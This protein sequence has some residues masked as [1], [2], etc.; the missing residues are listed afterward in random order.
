MTLR[1]SLHY[2][3][4]LEANTLHDLL[5][6]LKLVEVEFP[7]FLEGGVCGL[8]K[9]DGAGVSSGTMAGG[10]IDSVSDKRELRLM[11]AEHPEDT[12]TGVDA[13]FQPELLAGPVGVGV[14]K[15]HHVGS[16]F[17][18]P[19]GVGCLLVFWPL[20]LIFY[21]FKTPTGHVSL[22]NCFYFLDT[23]S[24]AEVI[25]VAEDLIQ[26]VDD[27]VAIVLHHGIELAN[28]AKKDGHFSSVVSN[29]VF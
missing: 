25:K 18:H 13:D 20:E 12:V 19:E 4:V 27:T 6:S 28:I 15:V 26:Q 21:E 2:I 14:D 9:N 7:S 22:A 1:H 3:G 24:L 16:E 10:G 5:Y 29:E 8:T 17:Y 23:M 11:V